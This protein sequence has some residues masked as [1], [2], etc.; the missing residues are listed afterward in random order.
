[1]ITEKEK[2]ML[3][4]SVDLSITNLTQQLPTIKDEESRVQL[5]GVLGEFL[6]LSEKVDK[7]ETEKLK[8]DV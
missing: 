8:K 1:M 4:G 3:K 2:A 5:R 6:S 7:L